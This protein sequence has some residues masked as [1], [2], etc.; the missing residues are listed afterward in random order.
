MTTNTERKVSMKNLG[1][2]G[3]DMY[4]V[5]DDGEIYSFYSS[6]FLKFSIDR[7]G[8]VRYTL[9]NEDGPKAITGHRAVASA[10]LDN[11]DS[12]ETVNHKD[13]DK[14]NNHYTN[15]EWCS[16][17]DNIVHAISTGLRKN[18][19]GRDYIGIESAHKIC[20]LM[21][22][23]VRPKEVAEM[24]GISYKIVGSI[25]SGEKWKHVSHEYD[26]SMMP[27]FCRVSSAKVISICKMLEKGVSV[28]R[29]VNEVS[30]SRSLVYKIKN[31]VSNIDISRSFIW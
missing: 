29:I 12:L 26:F 7:Y 20:S 13:G 4:A 23:G 8:Y 24:L 10:Y 18:S 27:K 3:F 22:Q 25:R 30:V 21:E 1:C 14:K 17:K 15:L 9:Y 16:V 6:K 5:T 28:K 31:R 11:P 2:I 19:G